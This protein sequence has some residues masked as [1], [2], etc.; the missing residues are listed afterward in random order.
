LESRRNENI[1]F[2]DGAMISKIL[3]EE[4]WAA[5]VCQSVTT[6]ARMQLTAVIVYKLQSTEK[7]RGG[8]SRT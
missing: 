7:R 5:G 2:P 8:A 3:Q 1:C 6:R 4:Q